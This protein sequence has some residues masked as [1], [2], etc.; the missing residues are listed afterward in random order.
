MSDVL[1]IH[2]VRVDRE[3][4]WEALQRDKKAR[5]GKIRLVLLEELGKPVVREVD[6]G[7]VRLALDELI[8]D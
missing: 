4:A 5:N 3:R 2:P 6:P 8:T 1:D 7:D